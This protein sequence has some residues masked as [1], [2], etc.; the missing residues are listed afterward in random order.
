MSYTL[1]SARTTEREQVPILLLNGHITF[2]ELNGLTMHVGLPEDLLP[3]DVIMQG[4]RMPS[5]RRITGKPRAN[6]FSIRY[7][8]WHVTRTD[9]DVVLGEHQWA[10]TAP[11]VFFR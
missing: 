7:V 1:A 3:G 8:I 10:S 6:V 9:S 5:F 11:V 2:P 4:G